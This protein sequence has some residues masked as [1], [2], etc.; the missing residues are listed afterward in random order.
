MQRRFALCP[1]QQ[2]HFCGR[3]SADCRGSRNPITL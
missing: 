1:G 2:G 3:I